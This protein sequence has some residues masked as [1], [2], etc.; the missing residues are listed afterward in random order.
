M[1]TDNLQVALEKTG[2]KGKVVK[3]F[4]SKFGVAYEVGL[5]DLANGEKVIIKIKKHYRSEKYKAA[6]S[7]EVEYLNLKFLES[8]N[9]PYI[10]KAL[11]YDDGILLMSFVSGVP[12]RQVEQSSLAP[13]AFKQMGKSLREINDCNTDSLTYLM[14]SNNFAEYLEHEFDLFYQERL[15][16]TVLPQSFYDAFK[17]EMFSKVNSDYPADIVLIAKDAYGAENILVENGTLSGLIDFEDLMIAPR[18]LQLRLPIQ[19]EYMPLFI[20]GYGKEVFERNYYKPHLVIQK[21]ISSLRA[22]YLATE[23]KDANYQ[24]RCIQNLKDNLR[25][26][27]STLVIPYQN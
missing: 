12:L 26:L 15:A 5:V 25:E 11:Y 17:A 3:T 27:G 6:Y 23:E 1:E 14:R 7:R 18:L 24:G 9:S 22:F 10:P 19:E 20:E 2:Y 21:A 13:E 4:H 16:L 8:L